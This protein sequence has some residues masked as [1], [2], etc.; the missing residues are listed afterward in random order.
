L[1]TPNTGWGQTKQKTQQ[2][3]K[4]MIIHKIIANSNT[5]IML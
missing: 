2:K 5:M 3:I 4:K 1:S